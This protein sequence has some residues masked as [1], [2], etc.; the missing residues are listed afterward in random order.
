[1]K[2]II[3]KKY[4]LDEYLNYFKGRE[5]YIAYQGS[6][7]Y[8]P[9]EHEFNESLLLKHIEGIQTLGVYVLTKASQCNFICIDID[10]PKNKLHEFDFKN[11]E[12]KF[13]TL[14]E[15]LFK[16]IDDLTTG[17]LFSNNNLLIEDTGGRG[18]HLWIFFENPVDGALAIQLNKILKAKY[19]FES[20][21]FPKQPFL[22]EKRRYGNLIKLPLGL[23]KKYNKRSKFLA[24]KDGQA[25]TFDTVEAN[26]LHLSEIKKV[27]TSTFEKILGANCEL[28]L[29][30]SRFHKE[31][32]E[33]KPR[34]IY[35]SDLTRLFVNC[36]AVNQLVEKAKKGIKLSHLE[37]FHLSNILL[38]VNDS[39]IDLEHLL[40]LSYAED[41]NEEIANREI[42][43][44]KQ[45][46][47]TTCK[48]LVECKICFNY[49]R[50]ELKI[51][52]EDVLQRNTNPLSVWL[53]PIHV[54]KTFEK[55]ENI[56]SK[57]YEI[58]NI[59]IAYSR[60]K[61]YHSK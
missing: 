27:G 54:N 56:L 8:Y 15:Q 12:I 30:L 39:R 21:F 49:C 20:E 22:T 44:I 43:T 4:N 1:M 16:I 36:T 25:V 32:F 23:H 18:Y 46:Q 24:I 37:A 6:S 3:S 10:I 48:T 40:K 11:P 38:S 9:I 26:L 2:M 29:N 34:R 59:K 17:L 35:K 42:N 45:F 41:F 13:Q 51:R 61:H 5:E 14:K 53:E 28:S 7:H 55:P 60:L 33:P 58:D 57:I 47:P 19:Q 31:N 50:P 52:N